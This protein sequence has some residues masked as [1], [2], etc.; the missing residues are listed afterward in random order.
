MQTINLFLSSVFQIVIFSIP[1]AIWW[2]LTV[3][4][5]ISFEEWL[6]LKKPI[7]EDKERFIVSSLFIIA[8]YT[9]MYFI[10]PNLVEDSELATSQF[11]GQGIIALIPAVIYAF[12]QTGFSEELL[13]R[14][15]LA[16]RFISKFGFRIGNTIQGLIFGIMHGAIFW[17]IVGHFKSIIIIIITSI[18]GSLLGWINEK[19]SSGSIVPSIVLHGIANII[20]SIISMFS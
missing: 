16:K 8:F 13:F 19:Q 5:Q 9:V 15:F 11:A 20:A 14:G 17:D 10:I 12:L 7:I 3:K 4:K 1:P 18:I 6:G 2:S